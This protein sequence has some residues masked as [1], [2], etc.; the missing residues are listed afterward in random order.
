MLTLVRNN[1]VD[2]VEEG[3]L[4]RSALRGLLIELDPHSAFMEA[5]VYE[6]M[7][8]D[9]KGEFHGLGVEI[10]KR[11]ETYCLPQT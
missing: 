11:P 4:L 2:P 8:V 9:T 6:D 10:S 5:E 3:E 1:Y 7:Q